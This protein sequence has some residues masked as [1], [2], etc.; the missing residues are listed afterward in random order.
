MTLF[1]RFTLHAPVLPSLSLFSLLV[2]LLGNELIAPI[3]V[4]QL[5][6]GELLAHLLATVVQQGGLLEQEASMNEET[7]RRRVLSSA[8]KMWARAIEPSLVRVRTTF[9]L[10]ACSSLSTLRQLITIAACSG[11][12]NGT[13][14]VTSHGSDAINPDLQAEYHSY[15]S[16]FCSRKR[17][18]ASSS[19][20]L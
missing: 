6:V 19:R 4:V 1:S 8:A 18:A 3:G 13:S 12:W 17:A 20:R 2:G 7:Q 14:M 5:N 11:D 16:I 9:P 15:Y 10:A